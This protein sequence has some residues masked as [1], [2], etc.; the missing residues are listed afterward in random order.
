MTDDALVLRRSVKA[1]GEDG[2]QCREVE[3][4]LAE[5]GDHVLLSRYV[6]RYQHQ[7]SMTHLIRWM[8]AHGE[9]VRT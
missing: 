8:M 6:E 1:L 4:R 9:R 2:L 5:D 7:V 3:L